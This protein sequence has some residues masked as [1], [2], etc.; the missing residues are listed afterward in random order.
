[1]TETPSGIVAERRCRTY[2]TLS[3]IYLQTL[4]ESFLQRL[5]ENLDALVRSV[6]DE[7]PP[8]W[9]NLRSGLEVNVMPCASQHELLA[10]ASRTGRR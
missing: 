6:G 3:E 4:S 9:L 7:L 2:W 1:M 8:V 10:P 5:R